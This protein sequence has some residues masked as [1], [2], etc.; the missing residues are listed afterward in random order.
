MRYAFRDA[1]GIVGINHKLF[2]SARGAK[3]VAYH[4]ICKKNHTRFN[5]IFLTLKCFESHL[6]FYKRYFHVISL[7]DFYDHKFSEEHFNIC[8]TF[9]D[10]FANNFRYVLPLMEKYQVPVTFFI[11]AIRDAGYD[12]LWND[13]LALAQKFGPEEF[14]FGGNSFYKNKKGNYVSR[15]TSKYLKNILQEKGFKEKAELISMLEPFTAFRQR[16]EEQDYWLQMTGDQIKK[17]ASSPFSTIGCHGYYH[18]DLSQISTSDA[19]NEISRSK[20]YLESITSKEIKAFAFP[21]GN[22][23]SDVVT[24]A[25]SAG[26]KQLLTTGFRFAEDYTDPQMRERLT[27]NPYI[28]LHNQMTAIVKGKY[29]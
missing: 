29:E 15:N 12:I 1:R 26:F 23:T 11:T 2:Q 5:S 17:L 28:S 25:K 14:E 22:Y 3:I 19:K 20:K 16:I 21:Y 6:Q 4:G 13:F 24:E 18:N 10:G 8:I 27:I 7:D 9:D